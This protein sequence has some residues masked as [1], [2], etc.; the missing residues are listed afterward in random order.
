[1]LLFLFFLF[2]SGGKAIR[3]FFPTAHN[4]PTQKWKTQL[5]KFNLN[6]FRRNFFFDAKWSSLWQFKVQLRWI[7]FW[8]V[9]QSWNLPTTTMSPWSETVWNDGA[10]A[11]TSHRYRP[12]DSRFTFSSTTWVSVELCNWWRRKKIKR[13]L[14]KVFGFAN[15]SLHQHWLHSDRIL[16]L[17]DGL[18]E[19]NGKTHNRLIGKR[20]KE[21]Y[22]FTG[23]QSW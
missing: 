14:G 22:G 10:S 21:F 23:Q 4:F 2:H 15:K 7:C 3:L 18:V 1:M 13:P 11:E 8:L 17:A 5:L 9:I 12:D 16:G 6:Q 19:H 20:K